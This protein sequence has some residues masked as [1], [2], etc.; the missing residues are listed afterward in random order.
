MIASASWTFN[1]VCA[2][3]LLFAHR[4]FF[5]KALLGTPENPLQSQYGSSFQAA[6]DAA[7]QIGQHL[8]DQFA[9]LPTL[10][11]Y[12]W[13]A[14]GAG[15]SA[16][17]RAF[18]IVFLHS[19]LDRTGY[20]QMV[21]GL[22]TIHAPH[23]PFAHPAYVELESL[24]RTFSDAAVVGGRARVALVSHVHRPALCVGPAHS[25]IQPIIQRLR[26]RAQAVLEGA[27]VPSPQDPDDDELALFAGHMHVR[28]HRVHPA[29]PAPE[30]APPAPAPPVTAPTGT[31]APPSYPPPTNDPPPG[32]AWVDAAAAFYTPHAWPTAE[33]VAAWSDVRTYPLDWP[34]LPVVSGQFAPPYMAPTRLDGGGYHGHGDERSPV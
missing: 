18:A 3:A 24:F 20:E 4:S 13:Y 31:Y 2:V 33:H 23:S 32:T 5:V 6:Y 7:R 34:P 10:S 27:P 17:V 30:P 12:A 19:T 21:L 16:A 25:Y 9:R 15:F 14:W 22:T 28:V 29:P 1:L 26:D 11:V 8:R